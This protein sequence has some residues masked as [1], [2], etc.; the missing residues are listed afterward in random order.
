[1][2][3]FIHSTKEEKRHGMETG[4]G[5]QAM[6]RKTKLQG[7]S[8]VKCKQLFPLLTTSR[9]GVLTSISFDWSTILK[10]FFVRNSSGQ[11]ENKKFLAKNKTGPPLPQYPAC[12]TLDLNDHLE[13]IPNHVS[14]HFYR[15]P[16]LAL[17][18]EVVD[19]LKSLVKRSL[20]WDSFDYE[21]EK[22]RLDLATV[23]SKLYALTLSQTI[24]L[25]ADEGKNCKNYPNKEFASYRECD[26]NF[27]YNEI[28]EHYKMMPFW[29]AKTIEEI[30]DIEYE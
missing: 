3:T 5:G 22:L 2:I 16:N 18:I 29:A 4:L 15:V 13:F 19:S 12:F 20:A 27:V 25:E 17:T 8:Q 11:K 9:K 23:Q 21:G 6:T 14:F 30:T 24:N 28:Q 7:Q 1:M 26:E 10:G